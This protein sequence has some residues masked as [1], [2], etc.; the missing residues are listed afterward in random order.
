MIQDRRIDVVAI[1]EVNN[2]VER[3]HN[4][5]WF[6]VSYFQ[7]S[8]TFKKTNVG[9]F[10][11]E[12]FRLIE[13]DSEAAAKKKMT[14]IAIQQASELDTELINNLPAICKFN[15]INKCYPIANIPSGDSIIGYTLLKVDNNKKLKRLFRNKPVEVTY[16]FD[17]DKSFD[18]LLEP[19]KNNNK[20]I[21]NR[22]NAEDFSSIHVSMLIL[23]VNKKRHKAPW[24]VCEVFFLVDDILYDDV[25]KK[26]SWRT[27]SYKIKEKL[28]SIRILNSIF[29]FNGK[30]VKLIFGDINLSR[31]SNFNED[32]YNDEPLT[33]NA[34]LAYSI[35][36]FGN[37]KNAEMILNKENVKMIAR[38]HY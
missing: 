9:M 17:S 30:K 24:F 3:R 15:G 22:K 6:I 36:Y 4:M 26:M 33:D 5:N 25:C 13:A 8:Q 10:V 38:N 31:V 23:E 16:L 7:L 18:L 2:Q 20:G 21:F 35:F 12:S 19:I 14:Q 29:Q 11:E 32:T 34:E 1:L 37:E 27:F 28:K